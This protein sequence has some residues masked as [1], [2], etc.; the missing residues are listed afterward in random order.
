[1]LLDGSSAWSRCCDSDANNFQ[2][3]RHNKNT[4]MATIT[5]RQHHLQCM[6]F[7]PK[8]QE[9]NET[10]QLQA[11]HICSTPRRPES[12]ARPIT[13]FD[14][15]DHSIKPPLPRSRAPTWLLP[16]RRQLQ[17]CWRRRRLWRLPCLQQP[18]GTRTERPRNSPYHSSQSRQH[19][20][21]K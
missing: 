4:T 15:R 18:H 14:T 13:R 1:L 5:R 12:T 7:V 20:L 19:H 21:P 6:W 8:N 10:H 16:R 2:Q 17:R 9:R 11:Q 3:L